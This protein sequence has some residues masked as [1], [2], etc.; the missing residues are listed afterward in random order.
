MGWDGAPALFHPIANF[1]PPARPP[2][3]AAQLDGYTQL[4][5]RTANQRSRPN[6]SYIPSHQARPP[7]TSQ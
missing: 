6:Q 2:G 7:D 1:D 4:P 5:K 3:P